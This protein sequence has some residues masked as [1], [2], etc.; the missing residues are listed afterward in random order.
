[1]CLRLCGRDGNILYT[2]I[3]RAVEIIAFAKGLLFNH[4]IEGTES[5]VMSPSIPRL[6]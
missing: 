5:K 6:I 1:M 4:G 2:A 3:C